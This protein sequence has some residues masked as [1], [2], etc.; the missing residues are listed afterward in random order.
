MGAHFK[1][2]DECVLVTP[3]DPR[4]VQVGFNLVSVQVCDILVTLHPYATS[5]MIQNSCGQTKLSAHFFY[6]LLVLLRVLKRTVCN[7]I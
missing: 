3:L 6:K 1:A 5:F 2:L 7:P 4:Y